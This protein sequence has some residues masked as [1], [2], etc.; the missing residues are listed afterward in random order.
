MTK[1]DKPRLQRPFVEIIRERNCHRLQVDGSAI[2]ADHTCHALRE[3]G[4]EYPRSC[5]ARQS[6]DRYCVASINGVPTVTP[7]LSRRVWKV[8]EELGYYPNTQARAL[9]SGRSRILV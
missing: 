4:S 1:K 5:E 8:I 3:I 9:V 2:E 6:F 7:Q